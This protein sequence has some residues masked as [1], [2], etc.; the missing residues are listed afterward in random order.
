MSEPM[1]IKHHPSDALIVD[2][3][4]GAMGPAQAMVLATHIHAC[5]DCR[6]RA[7]AAEAAGGVLLE[8]LAQEPM[9]PDALDRALASLDAVEQPGSELSPP[10]RTRAPQ[11]ADWIRVPPEVAEAER[12]KRWVAP[13]VW[14]APVD[15]GTPGGPLS[16]LLRVGQR[17]R[18]P[19]HTH[20]GC[21]LTL[22]LKGAFVDGRE[23]YGPGDIAEADDDVE[24]SPAILDGEECVCLVAC[25]NRLIVKDWLGR[26]VQA[27]AGI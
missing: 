25:D 6:A 21:E 2:Y 7:E 9:S 4:S 5:A 14:V 12:R 27:Y 23:K 3:A 17:M 15:T 18:M 24:H 11:P 22:V 20:S 10:S 13:G 26:L 1:S 19:Q 16:Y 8:D